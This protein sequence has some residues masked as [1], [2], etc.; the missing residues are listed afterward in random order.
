M[1]AE[2]LDVLLQESHAVALETE[3]LAVEDLSKIVVDATVQEK[4]IAFPTDAKLLNRARVTLVKLAKHGGGL[5]QAC[6]GSASARSLRTSATGT[7]GS[8][9]APAGSCGGSRPS[10]GA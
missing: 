5:R 2:R 1:G 6:P 3:A 8:S 7:P 4:A 10:S 9:G